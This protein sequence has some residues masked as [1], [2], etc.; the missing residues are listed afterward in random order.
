MNVK[1][2]Q[3]FLQSLIFFILCCLI[4]QW[5]IFSTEFSIWHIELSTYKIFIILLLVS[6]AESPSLFKIFHQV[7]LLSH[8]GCWILPQSLKVTSLLFEIYSN[9]L[10]GHWSLLKFEFWTMFKEEQC[11]KKKK[12][13]KK[14][15]RGKKAMKF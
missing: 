13:C 10:W 7:W 12:T 3:Y 9:H 15:L 2:P 4:Y 1:I 14:W 11:L 8:P 5:L 6:F